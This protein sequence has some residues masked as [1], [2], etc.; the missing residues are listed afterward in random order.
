MLVQ[1]KAVTPNLVLHERKYLDLCN[2]WKK[3]TGIRKIKGQFLVATWLTVVLQIS[4]KHFSQR[5]ITKIARPYWGATC[6]FDSANRLGQS[7]TQSCIYQASL[8]K[9]HSDNTYRYLSPQYKNVYQKHHLYYLISALPWMICMWLPKL[10]SLSSAL[11]KLL[12]MTSV[13]GSVSVKWGIPVVNICDVLVK[14]HFHYTQCLLYSPPCCQWDAYYCT[15]YLVD[16]PFTVS[17]TI[18]DLG[19][20]LFLRQANFP[21]ISSP[22]RGDN[23]PS[24]LKKRKTC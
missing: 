2:L 11:H 18:N 4:S 13:L 19:S 21:L 14:C 16:R 23:I 6:M 3:N 20:F 1:H 10:G 17:V 15:R 9:H 5:N 12:N 22:E 24:W 8:S 7:C